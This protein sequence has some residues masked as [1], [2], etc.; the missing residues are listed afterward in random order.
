MKKLLIS[1]IV[2]LYFSISLFSV[3]VSSLDDETQAVIKELSPGLEEVEVV[4]S[5]YTDDNQCSLYYQTEKYIIFIVDDKIVII[6]K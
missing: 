5:S 6:K 3:A 4:D 2:M 1:L